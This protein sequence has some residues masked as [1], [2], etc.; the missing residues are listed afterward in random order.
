VTILL[1]MLVAMTAQP[2]DPT[3]P[4]GPL[5]TPKQRQ[6]TAQQPTASTSLPAPRGV[7]YGEPQAP[8]PTPKDPGPSPTMGA[9]P[10][11]LDDR[12][13]VLFDGTSW[14]GWRQRDL[15]PSKWQVMND[16]TVQVVPSSDA[17]SKRELGDFQLH[18]EFRCP[19]MPGRTGQAKG[20]SGVYLHGRY[21]IQVLD[22]FG[23]PPA[24][25]GCGGI[26]SIAAPLVNASRPGGEWQT[27]DI[28]FRAPRFDDNGQVTQL[29]RVTVLH[30]GIVIHDNLELHGTTPGGLDG[31]MVPSGPLLLQDHGD[32][33]RYR[34]IWMR[35]LD[36]P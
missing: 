22:S 29:P 9:K 35:A 11:A 28:A 36:A 23:D 17:L 32:P 18:L 27:Y 15:A 20:N 2:A 25:N 24:G 3:H 19:P 7:A 26:Y 30:N 21:E 5:S 10:P 13:V 4:N 1:M 6:W 14:D 31:D 8:Q 12:T 34:N 33:V 16:G